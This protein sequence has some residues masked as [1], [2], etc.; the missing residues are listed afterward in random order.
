MCSLHQVEV[1][2]RCFPRIVALRDGVI[3]YDGPAAS[4]TDAQVAAL[5]GARGLH[6]EAG[7][8]QVEPTEPAAPGSAKPA[9]LICR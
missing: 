4:F 7:P 8:P 6:A 9:P 1:A 5:Y 3:V 2:R